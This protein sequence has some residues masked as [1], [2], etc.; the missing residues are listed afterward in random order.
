M[1]IQ[2]LFLYPVKSL[3]G[4]AVVSAELTPQG[5]RYDRHWMIIDQQNTFI[6]QRKT[7]QMVLINTHIT[8]DALVLT[9]DGKPSMAVPLARPTGPSFTATVWRDSCQVVAESDSV[10]HWVTDALQYREPLRLVRLAHHQ[11]RPA[12][13]P[14]RFGQATSRFADA[15]PYLI[16]HQTS[17]DHLN[18]CLLEQGHDSVTIERF[19]PNIVIDS[20]GQLPAFAEHAITHIRGNT[21][22]LTHC[23]PCERCI[24]PNIDLQTAQ[25]HPQQQPYK[26]LVKINPMPNNRKAAAFGHN[27]ILASGS[28]ALIRVGDAIEL[29]HSDDNKKGGL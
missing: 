5:L 23:D 18:D 15:A 7:P 4:I 14:E 10:N 9:A 11:R 13:Q 3:R 20:G 22:S 1:K 12:S 24:V 16:G 19:R 2:Q 29:Q 8:D 26:T 28:G 17:L 6:T 27:A 25:K 21:Y